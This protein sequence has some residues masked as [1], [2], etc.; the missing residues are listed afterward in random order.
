MGPSWPLR[1]PPHT[2]T[3]TRSISSGMFTMAWVSQLSRLLAKFR[4]AWVKAPGGGSGAGGDSGRRGAQGAGAGWGR[5][6]HSLG[7]GRSTSGMRI[8]TR[9]WYSTLSQC[10]AHCSTGSNLE[11]STRLAL[12]SR[13]SASSCLWA[14][15]RPGA[16]RGCSTALHPGSERHSTLTP[17]WAQAGTLCLLKTPGVR[18]IQAS[19]P[20]QDQRGISTSCTWGPRHLATVG[21]KWLGG[22]RHPTHRASDWYPGTLWRRVQKATGAPQTVGVREEPPPLHGLATP[23][24]RS[25]SQVPNF[26]PSSPRGTHTAS[27]GASLGWLRLYLQKVFQSVSTSGNCRFTM[28]STMACWGGQMLEG[29][30]RQ[31][32]APHPCLLPRCPTSQCSRYRTWKALMSPGPMPS[33]STLPWRSSS[34]KSGRLLEASGGQRR[35][36]EPLPVPPAH[37]FQPHPGILLSWHHLA[38]KLPHD[39]LG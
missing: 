16:L 23:A 21:R 11:S 30:G 1:P 5:G 12:G 36:H 15:T 33:G 19:L 39:Q 17:P 28:T 37:P 3:F 6:G 26:L 24:L 32:G 10:L 34:E 25:D 13:F 8:S 29:V 38:T 18:L 14:P 35:N 7:M 27:G 20:P 31:H 22:A 9:P 4:I 2:L